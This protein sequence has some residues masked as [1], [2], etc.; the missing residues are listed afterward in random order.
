M[1]VI[2]LIFCKDK[3]TCPF[4]QSF[5]RLRADLWYRI[6]P[7]SAPR[8]TPQYS[9]NGKCKAFDGAVLDQRL[10]RIFRAS[11]CKSTRRRRERRD[12]LPIKQNGHKQQPG[13]HPRYSTPQGKHHSHN[14]SPRRAKRLII[15][16]STKA[17]SCSFPSIQINAIATALS[18]VF[19]SCESTNCLFF[20]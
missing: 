2:C 6:I 1:K 17:L 18:G 3:L 11:G 16:C 5:R 20:R 13:Q 10:T 4:L 9:P 7:A 8:I 19:N 12:K 14:R 15:R